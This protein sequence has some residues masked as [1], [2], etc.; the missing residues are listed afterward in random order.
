MRVALG[1][2]KGL[3]FLHSAETK[4]IYRDFKTSNVLLDSEYNAKLSDFGLARDAPT[5]NLSHVSTKVMG[6]HGYAAPEYVSTGRLTTKSDVYGFGVVFLEMLSGR[7]TI[8]KNRPFGEHN[9]V[10]WA[11]PFL[12]NKHKLYRVLDPRIEGQ[13][14]LG[15]ALRATTLALQCL[16]HEAKPRPSMIEV[17][18][19]LEQLQDSDGASCNELELGAIFRRGSSTAERVESRQC[20]G[21]VVSTPGEQPVPGKSAISVSRTAPSSF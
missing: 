12:G 10:E 15:K 3:A 2:A 1:A 13:Y 9:L 20:L 8:D 4:V 21:R 16:S 7:R 11:R 18:E 5:G 17:V 14:S 6:T 19:T